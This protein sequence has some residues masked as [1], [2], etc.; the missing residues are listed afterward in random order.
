M[1]F[2]SRQYPMVLPQVYISLLLDLHNLILYIVTLIDRFEKHSVT[3]FVPLS[4][5]MDVGTVVVRNSGDDGTDG[6]GTSPEP[7]PV[8]APSVVWIVVVVVMSV[9]RMVPSA[10]MSRSVVW[11]TV[12][13]RTVARR[14]YTR[15]VTWWSNARSVRLSRSVPRRSYAGSVRFSR[16]NRFP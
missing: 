6:D 16:P 14:S 5:N 15:S 11:R 3:L 12:G 9:V 4:V 7:W 1:I 2:A 10:T 8:A 13:R